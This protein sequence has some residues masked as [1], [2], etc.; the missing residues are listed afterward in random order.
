MHPPGDLAEPQEPS[1]N[2]VRLG[3]DH[4]EGE[5]PSRPR[6][7]RRSPAGSRA[8][9]PSACPVRVPAGELRECTRSPCSVRKRSSS[10]SGLIPASSRRKTFRISSSSKTTEVFDC[11]A[12]MQPRPRAAPAPSSAKP[13]DAAELDDSLARRAPD[14]RA[15]TQVHELAHLARVRERVERRRRSTSSWYVSCVPVSKRISTSCSSRRGSTSRSIALSMTVARATSRA[16]RPEP[17]LA[18]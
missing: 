10:S 17:A 2:V 3:L 8:S 12:S 9:R 7:R 4:R 11:S 15:R 13:L 14:V 6:H 18:R 5:R 1:R 16:L